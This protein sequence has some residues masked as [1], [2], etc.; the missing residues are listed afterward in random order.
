MNTKNKKIAS[1][2]TL[3]MMIGMISMLAFGVTLALL[4]Q[5][6]QAMNN[7]FQGAAVNIGVLENGILYEDSTDGTNTGYDQ[8]QETARTQ[9][10]TIQIENIDSEAYPTTDTYVR[11]RLVPVLRYDSESEYAG[12]SV[13]VD[14]KGHVS[15]TYG[16]DQWKYVVD[17]NG[18]TYYYYDQAIA[19]GVSTEPLITAVTYSGELPA[20][21]Y[22]EVQVLTEGLSALQSGSTEDAWGV[23]Y[24]NSAGF[25]QISTMVSVN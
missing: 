6:T 24:D 14:T 17:T 2:I 8:I 16:S 11:V 23:T 12:Q 5:K 4:N 25:I 21:T 22:F 1:K 19:P 7:S 20:N 18:E 3:I 13:P 10:K 9:D 15:Y